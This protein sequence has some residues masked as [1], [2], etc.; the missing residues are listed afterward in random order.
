MDAAWADEEQ[1]QFDRLVSWLSDD[2]PTDW[3]LPERAVA[4]AA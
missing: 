1:W 2:E 4:V 3:P